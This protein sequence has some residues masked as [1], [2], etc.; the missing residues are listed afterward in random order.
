MLFSIPLLLGLALGA[1][2][3]RHPGPFSKETKQ[4]RWG[5]APDKDIVRRSAGRAP[6]VKRA[7]TI[8]PKIFIISLV[9]T[10]AETLDR[11]AWLTLVTTV[12]LRSKCLV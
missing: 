12:R 3:S 5:S 1:C 11:L 10:I 9:W 2:A 8:S 6:L 7:E 4:K